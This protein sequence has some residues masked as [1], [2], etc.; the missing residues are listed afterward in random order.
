MIQHDITNNRFYFY[1]KEITEK[2]F[3]KIRE[4]MDDMPT[5]P[6]GHFYIL[7]EALEWELCEYP[8]PPEDVDDAELLDILFGGAE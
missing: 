2:Q 1:G 5:A 8:K 4:I 3:N 7:T 6:P